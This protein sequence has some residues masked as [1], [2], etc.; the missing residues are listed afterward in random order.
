MK[1]RRHRALSGGKFL[2][3][4]FEGAIPDLLPKK[5]PECRGSSGCQ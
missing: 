5:V 4:R 2:Y 3:T 1:I